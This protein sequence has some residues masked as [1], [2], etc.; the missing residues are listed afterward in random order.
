M[1]KSSKIDDS[2]IKKAAEF[3]QSEEANKYKVPLY[4]CVSCGSQFYY[5]KRANFCSIC[6]SKVKL[7][8]G[9]PDL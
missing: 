7:I 3:A 5:S 1:S 4:E 2:L 6:G 8:S 9:N